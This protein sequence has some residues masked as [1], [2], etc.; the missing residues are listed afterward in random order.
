MHVEI[1]ID[2][3]QWSRSARNQG[4]DK[5]GE[6]CTSLLVEVFMKV[7]NSLVM[8]LEEDKRC[9]CVWP[10]YYVSNLMALTP[11]AIFCLRFTTSV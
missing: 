5:R 7:M 6:I 2:F 8:S 3:E 9:L 4:H 1:S 11:E 10:F